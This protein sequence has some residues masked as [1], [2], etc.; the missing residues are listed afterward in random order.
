MIIIFG[1]LKEA[2]EVGP[3]LDCYCY[4]CQR[5]RPWEHWKETEWVTFF[6]I[7]TVPF[8]S[9][10]HVVCAACRQPIRLDGRQIRQL[11]DKEQQTNLVNFLEGHQLAT[12]SELQRN[13]LLSQRAQNERNASPSA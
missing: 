10:N 11:Q 13:F 7:R 5:A 2:R 4:R 1:W 6:N 12:K 9:K 8:L 3:G